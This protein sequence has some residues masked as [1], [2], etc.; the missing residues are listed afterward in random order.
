MSA[1]QRESS[2]S[3]EEA[4]RLAAQIRPSWEMDDDAWGS[5]NKG[6][7]GADPQARAAKEAPAAGSTPAKKTG[8]GAPP[9]CSASIWRR[10]NAVSAVCGSP[11]TGSGRPQ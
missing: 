4:E 3:P 1:A 2:L 9:P 5:G 8:P 10:R 6:P 7:G 11:V